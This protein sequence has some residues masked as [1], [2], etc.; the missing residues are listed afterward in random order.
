MRASF[1]LKVT[2]KP[3]RVIDR[4]VVPLLVVPTVALSE[5][6]SRFEV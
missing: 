3:G 5:P 2:P 4:V 6:G 1:P